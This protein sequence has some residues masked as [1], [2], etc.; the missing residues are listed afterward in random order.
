MA[1][2]KGK[3]GNVLIIVKQHKL[4]KLNL[5]ELAGILIRDLRT[6]LYGG[7]LYLYLYG[8]I[9]QFSVKNIF[10]FFF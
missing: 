5:L 8:L 6:A 9:N 10:L 2:G 7:R 1:K 4:F 3:I